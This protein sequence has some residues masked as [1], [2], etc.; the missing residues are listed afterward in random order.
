[1]DRHSY[2]LKQYSEQ[3]QRIH[4]LKQLWRA[5]QEVDINANGTSGYV[6][7]QGVNTGRILAHT[8]TKSNQNW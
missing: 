8:S 2:M 6:L 4:K 5:R 7:K 3:Q 1:M